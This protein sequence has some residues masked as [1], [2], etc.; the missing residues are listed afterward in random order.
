MLSLGLIF[1]PVSL[2]WLKV[3]MFNFVYGKSPCKSDLL[4][5]KGR[6]KRVNQGGLFVA[7]L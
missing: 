1:S 3:L 2:L 5:S 6:S 7:E 4:A